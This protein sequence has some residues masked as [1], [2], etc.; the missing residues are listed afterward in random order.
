M[1][2]GSVMEKISVG[3]GSVIG[4]I[5]PVYRLVKKVRKIN[6]PQRIKEVEHL[7]GLV[8]FYGRL[9]PNLT[10]KIATISGL[11]KRSEAEFQWTKKLSRAFENLK[12]ELASKPVVQPYSLKKEVPITTDTSK[13]AICGVPSQV[14]HPV[15]YV[16][17]TLSQAEQKYSNYERMSVKPQR[18]FCGKTLEAV[19]SL[20]R[21]FNLETDHRPLEFMLAPNKELPKTV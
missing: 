9:I 5:E 6:T 3:S 16:S 2:S 10:S 14:G 7:C 13:K 19:F 1:N 4:G 17:K 20:G 18:L 21:K 12:S 11:R 15:I 8:K